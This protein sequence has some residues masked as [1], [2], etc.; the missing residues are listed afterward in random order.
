HNDVAGI[1]ALGAA[2]A[3]HLQ[4]VADVDTGRAGA[5]AGA[6]VDAVAQIQGDAGLFVLAL[7]AGTSSARFAARGV[8]ADDQRVLV[9]QNRL[10]TR[11][12][13]GDRTH[14]FAKIGEIK[15]NQGRG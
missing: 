14:L 1:D 4:A 3:F 11:V 12:R 9:H 15:Q 7:C 2:D 6:A 5:Y 13:T 10:K 8:V